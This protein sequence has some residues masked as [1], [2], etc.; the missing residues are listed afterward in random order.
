MHWNHSWIGFG[1]ERKGASR[2]AGPLF[3]NDD[4]IGG[5]VAEVF[6]AHGADQAGGIATQ[7]IQQSRNILRGGVLH[8][9]HVVGVKQGLRV[10][11]TNDAVTKSGPVG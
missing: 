8:A 1:L 11:F 10:G 4:R 2:Q 5:V 9:V 3:T 6:D 7:Q